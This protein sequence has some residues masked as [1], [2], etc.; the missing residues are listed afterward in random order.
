MKI[1]KIIFKYRFQLKIKSLSELIKLKASFFEVC[2][3]HALPYGATR[4]FICVPTV[5]FSLQHV[6]NLHIR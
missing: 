6:E 2:A 4:A 3:K 1:N 5:L